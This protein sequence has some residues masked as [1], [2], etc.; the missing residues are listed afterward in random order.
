MVKVVP[1]PVR[2]LAYSRRVLWPCS[3]WPEGARDR[4]W[5]M[6]SDRPPRR[7]FRPMPRLT[8]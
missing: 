8:A 3:V 2:V 1:V 7:E 5:V 6:S 4:L